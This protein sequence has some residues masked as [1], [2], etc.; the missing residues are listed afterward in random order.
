MNLA[1]TDAPY[2]SSDQSPRQTPRLT[3]D[4]VRFA[5]FLRLAPQFQLLGREH[6]GRTAAESCI[7]DRFLD[8][9]GA[10]LDSFLPLLLA[11]NCGSRLSGVAGIS[12]ASRTTLFLEQYLDTPIEQAVAEGL[13]RRDSAAGSV[14]GRAGAAGSTSVSRDSI[15]EIGNLVAASNGASLGIFIVLASA[16]HQAGFTH[17]VF[18]ATEKLRSK[19]NRLG[20]ETTL[21]ADADPTRLSSGDGVS[22]GS[23]YAN[24]PQV[25]T[26]E[27]HQAMTAIADSY[28][29]TCLAAAFSSQI[30]ALAA[31]LSNLRVH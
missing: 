27:L 6:P 18:T 12:Q 24:K 13:A 20:F 3:R 30:D 11:M 17:L 26:G 5:R 4:K 14:T 25:V 15:V 29:F 16:L 31:E 2:Q 22:W 23:Y 19:F 7:R 28:L 21:L 8:A 9:F 10:E 1:D